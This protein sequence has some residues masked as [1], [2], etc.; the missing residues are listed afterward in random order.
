MFCGA[1]DDSVDPATVSVATDDNCDAATKLE[2]QED[3]EPEEE[4]PMGEWYTGPFSK[5]SRLFVC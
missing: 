5:V 4:C 1:R 2:E 3:C